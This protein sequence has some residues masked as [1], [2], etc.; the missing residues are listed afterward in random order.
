MP[1][2]VLGL[3]GQFS[4]LCA[5]L[6]L[7]LLRHACGAAEL[8]RGDTL[9]EVALALLRTPMPRAVLASYQ[10]CG[11]I[12]HAITAAGVPFV[13]AFGNPQIALSD[14]IKRRGMDVAAATRLVGNGCASAISF[15]ALP[16]AL[17]LHPGSRGLNPAAVVGDIARHL[18]IAIDGGDLP[19]LIE[20]SDQPL[21]LRHGDDEGARQTNLDAAEEA[22][23]EGAIAPFVEYFKGGGLRQVAWAPELFFRGE[24]PGERATGAIDITGR[25]RCLVSG[26][27]ML[28]PAGGWQL[29]IAVEFSAA[30]AEYNFVLE[31]RAG[32]DRLARSIIRPE[33][34]GLIEVQQ[35]ILI[36][37]LPRRPIDLRLSSE[38]AAFDGAIRLLGVRATRHS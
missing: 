20:G 13:V 28:L 14:L 33:A 25:P 35:T 37:D 15:S 1:V 22:L 21:D 12:K 29:S 32:D 30:T 17:L 24:T 31:L 34:A 5:T 16:G 19:R 26:P 23:A 2:L 6:T 38:R 18:G 3:P 4:E 27:G 9:D 10:A 11:D 36:E 8:I 7:R